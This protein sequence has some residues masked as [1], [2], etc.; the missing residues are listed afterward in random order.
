MY[1]VIFSEAVKLRRSRKPA[2][3]S[4]ESASAPLPARSAE[5]GTAHKGKDPHPGKAMECHVPPHTLT[6]TM[7][8]Q[9]HA[10][11]PGAQVQLQL[12]PS[13]Q[14][15]PATPRQDRTRWK[16][17]THQRRKLMPGRPNDLEAAAAEPQTGV[18][19]MSGQQGFPAAEE[20]PQCAYVYCLNVCRASGTQ[21]VIRRR[22]APAARA[23]YDQ[24][25]RQFAGL[26]RHAG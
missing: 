17:P 26:Q 25:T 12:H 16:P 2:G 19:S 22:Q 13:H 10:R 1:I 23:N 11:N 6:H 24:G 9:G 21:G 5:T 18:S 7:Y 20:L 4:Q 8:I 3:G 14:R 15:V